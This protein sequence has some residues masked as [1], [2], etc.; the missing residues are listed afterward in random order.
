[1]VCVEIMS[2]VCWNRA[3]TYP[4]VTASVATVASAILRGCVNFQFPEM[5]WSEAGSKLE[6]PPDDA[7]GTARLKFAGV[8]SHCTSLLPAFTK[9]KGEIAINGICLAVSIFFVKHAK[10][11]RLALLVAIGRQ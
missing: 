3:L 11:I 2:T 7:P 6:P 8:T 4:R 1:M 5:F 10:H 9:I